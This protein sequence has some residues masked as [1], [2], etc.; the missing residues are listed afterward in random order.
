MNGVYV[1]QRTAPLAGLLLTLGGSL[2]LAGSSRYSLFTPAPWRGVPALLTAVRYPLEAVRRRRRR[3]RRRMVSG[4]FGG[5][6]GAG[7]S[8]VV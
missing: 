7:T 2:W 6:V 8:R 4:G 5:D 1:V 3:R